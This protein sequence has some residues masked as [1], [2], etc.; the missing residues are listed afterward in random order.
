MMKKFLVFLF[1]CGAFLAC[2][3]ENTSRDP[4]KYA[5]VVDGGTSNPAAEAE[6]GDVVTLIP[7]VPAGYEF[8]SWI[9]VSGDVEIDGTE[10]EMPDEPVEIEAVFVLVNAFPLITDQAFKEYCERFDT[11]S[12]YILSPE[13]CSIVESI[14]V[15]NFIDIASLAGIECFTEITHLDCGGNSLTSLDL[16]HNTRLEIVYCDN[17]DIASLNISENTLLEELDCSSNDITELDLSNNP[18]LESVSC[19]WNMMTVLDVSHLE[20]LNNLQCGSQQP[21]A[22][23]TLTLAPTQNDWWAVSMSGHEDN[24]RVVVAQ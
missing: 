7:Q 15:Y 22:T 18:L 19:E 24:D 10:F 5:I 9:V 20:Y 13:E 8:D 23:L 4:E 3:D 6:A 16:S 17:N 21:D 14:D 2:D 12:N 1:T 11:D